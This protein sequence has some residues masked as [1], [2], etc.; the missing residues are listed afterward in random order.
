VI[1]ENEKRGFQNVAKAGI[2]GVADIKKPAMRQVFYQNIPPG[3]TSL[4]VLQ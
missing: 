1:S 3:G 2:T 4:K